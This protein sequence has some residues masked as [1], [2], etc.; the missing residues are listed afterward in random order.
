MTVLTAVHIFSQPGFIAQTIFTPPIPSV[1]SKFNTGNGAISILTAETWKCL[2]RPSQEPGIFYNQL[3]DSYE[4][5]EQ[6]R[7]AAKMHLCFGNFSFVLSFREAFISIWQT[8]LVWKF[9]V[10]LLV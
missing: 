5:K 7:M 6:K 3:G 8:L 10:L 9:L 4:Q 1:T 2:Q